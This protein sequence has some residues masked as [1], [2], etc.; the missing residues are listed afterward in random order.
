MSH[1]N[2]VTY[3]Y[4]QFCGRFGKVAHVEGI[5]GCQQCLD[6]VEMILSAYSQVELKQKP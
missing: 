1:T 3:G 4:C 6:I 2:H 5:V